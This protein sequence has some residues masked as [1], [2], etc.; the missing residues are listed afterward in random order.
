MFSGV[1]GRLLAVS[2]VCVCVYHQFVK[3]IWANHKRLIRINQSLHR[4]ETNEWINQRKKYIILSGVFIFVCFCFQNCMYVWACMSHLND[5][6]FRKKILVF[7]DFFRFFFWFQNN[8][9]TTT[10]I[11]RWSD[12]DGSLK[13]TIK[14]IR[15]IERTNKTKKKWKQ[16]NKFWMISGC[17]CVCVWWWCRWWS[18][19]W[20]R[21]K[22]KK[23]YRWQQ[24]KMT[25]R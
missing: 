3:I 14:K 2:F 15:K 6:I 10:T 24:P 21:T 5:L 4:C 22:H 23:K 12:D 20:T 8:L 13:R 25:M 17:M 9:Q 19:W 16:T 7:L 1:Y 18:R 11:I